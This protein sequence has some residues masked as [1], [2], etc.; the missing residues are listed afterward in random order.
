MNSTGFSGYSAAAEKGSA[1]TSAARLI[2]TSLFIL[3]FPC[4]VCF[5]QFRE[6]F[7][8]G[9]RCFSCP[10]L[11]PGP[12]SNAGRNRGGGVQA[13]KAVSVI[14]PPRSGRRPW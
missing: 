1:V 13:C 14:F 10:A 8:L 11:V 2:C 12:L 5:S 6:L 9:L 3:S 4:F 7:F